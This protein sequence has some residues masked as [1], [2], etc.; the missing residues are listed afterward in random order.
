[1]AAFP[2]VL[3]VLWQLA[4]ALT[5]GAYGSTISLQLG[6]NLETIRVSRLALK[7]EAVP[8]IADSSTSSPSPSA[9]SS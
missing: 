5:K 8:Q 7:K 3:S 2:H 1:M 4:V 6:K 9:V